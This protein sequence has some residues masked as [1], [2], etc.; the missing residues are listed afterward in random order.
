MYFHKL[1]T[2]EALA[3]LFTLDWETGELKR[4]V[5]CK[6]I[7]LASQRNAGPTKERYKQVRVNGVQYRQHRIVLVLAT[8]QAIPEGMD[9]DH[10]NLNKHDNRP[11][12]LR[13]VTRS[14]NRANTRLA[15]TNSSGYKGV[16]YNPVRGKFE[17]QINVR[18]AR[19]RL[20]RFSTAEQAAQAYDAAALAANGEH[21]LTNAA[22]GLL[23]PACTPAFPYK[24]PTAFTVPLPPPPLGY[25]A[26][27]ANS[28]YKGAL[29][30]LH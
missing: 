14:Q 23:A 22:L 13:V 4:R 16:W 9:V 19:R 15:V 11:C 29:A 1:P 21:T 24:A 26:A 2:Y 27:L 12:N 3:E 6:S 10:I 8:G 17:A 25:I 18:G 5:P 28:P 20:G 30:T 7:N